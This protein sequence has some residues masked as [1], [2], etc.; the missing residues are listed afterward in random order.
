MRSRGHM[1]KKYLTRSNSLAIQGYEK[2]IYLQ[3]NH[4]QPP[5]RPLISNGH[6]HS[7]HELFLHPVNQ[8]Q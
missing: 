5:P 1:T 2:P 3:Y 7:R 4:P 6:W 8:C